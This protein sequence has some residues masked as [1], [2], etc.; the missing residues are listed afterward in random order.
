M[1]FESR[2]GH[3]TGP[4]LPTRELVLRMLVEEGYSDRI[5]KILTLW[6]DNEEARVEQGLLTNIEKNRRWADLLRDAG[7]L[8]DAR[9]C[10]E[11]LRTQAHQ[12]EDLYVFEYANVEIDKIDHQI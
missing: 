9:T 2:Q 6:N 1:S 11:D 5:F 10:Y 4:T 12:E 3:E 8:T 7:E